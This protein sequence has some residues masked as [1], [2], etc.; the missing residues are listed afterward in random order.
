M[1]WAYL[2]SAI[3]MAVAK[4]G[5]VVLLASGLGIIF[6]TVAANASRIIDALLGKPRA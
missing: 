4:M 1:A 2:T 5:A 3:V 6:L